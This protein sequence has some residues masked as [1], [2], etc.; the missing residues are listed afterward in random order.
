MN[1]EHG[2]TI[3]CDEATATALGESARRLGELPV[4]G[5]AAP[6]AVFSIA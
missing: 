5:K 3:L 6:V 4:R 2:T 1:K